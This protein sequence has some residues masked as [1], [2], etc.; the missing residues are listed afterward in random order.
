MP[1]ESLVILL[2]YL[3]CLIGIAVLYGFDVAA[4]VRELDRRRIKLPPQAF[5]QLWLAPSR[6]GHSLHFNGSL[7]WASFFAAAAGLVTQ[8]SL[9]LWWA[10][11]FE[12]NP[13]SIVVALTGMMMTGLILVLFTYLV[14][15][16]SRILAGRG[17]EMQIKQAL[18]WSLLIQAVL[19]IPAMVVMMSIKGSSPEISLLVLAMPWLIVMIYLMRMLQ[20]MHQWSIFKSMAAVLLPAT[21]CLPLIGLMFQLQGWITGYGILSTI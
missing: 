1:S 3:A 19:S 17:S 18:G 16:T 5:R 21:L 13:R 8:A 15:Y 2:P 4:Y 11:H 12:G 7:L 10:R 20:G 14:H 9:Q 6:F